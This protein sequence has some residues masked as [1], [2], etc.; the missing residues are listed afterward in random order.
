MTVRRIRRSTSAAWTFIATSQTPMPTPWTKSPRAARGT[1]PRTAPRAAAERPTVSASTPACTVAP[2]PIRSM[3]RPVLG[4]ASRDPHE[5]ASSSVPSPPLLSSRR[6]RRSGSRDTKEAKTSPLRAK[7]S[8]TALRAVSSAGAS[9][10]RR[11][12]VGVLTTP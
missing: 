2:A 6:S 12:T 11:I 1:L 9:G 5:I 8:A 4:S 7:E 10:S 3:T